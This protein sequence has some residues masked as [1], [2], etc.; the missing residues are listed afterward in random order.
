[1]TT[2]MVRMMAKEIAGEFYE[3]HQR[4]LRFRRQWPDQREFVAKCWKHFVDLARGALAAMLA[5]E[6]TPEHHKQAILAELIED[7][8]RQVDNP[9]AMD[10]IQATLDPREREDIRHIDQTPQLPGVS[11]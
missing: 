8:E 9:R 2:Q 10:V 5:R 7:H 1:M 6:D 3:G 11:G 4:T